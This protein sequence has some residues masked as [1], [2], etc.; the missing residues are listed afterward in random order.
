MTGSRNANCSRAV[1][2]GAQVARTEGRTAT[3]SEASS[4]RMTTWA[5]H[6]VRVAKTGTQTVL[7]AKA[8]TSHQPVRRCSARS[9][10]AGSG[11]VDREHQAG[12]V[13]QPPDGEGVARRGHR[14]LVGVGD[15]PLLDAG[16]DASEALVQKAW[17]T[18]M[19][20][21]VKLRTRSL[22]TDMLDTLRT[23]L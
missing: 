16:V 19:T 3:T 8:A 20:A 13:D 10:W 15:G 4:T 1:A 23:R 6:S 5:S 11:L 9:R 14:A 21:T 2:G 18:A 7:A 22:A 17:A 12:Q